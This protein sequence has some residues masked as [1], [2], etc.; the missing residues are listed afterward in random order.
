MKNRYLLRFK[1]VLLVVSTI[2]R[3][4][5]CE[6][7]DFVPKEKEVKAKI[8]KKLRKAASLASG[9]N[10]IVHTEIIRSEKFWDG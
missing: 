8:E 7:Y 3:T 4:F 6:D 10:S 2:D 5:T 1:T 9:E